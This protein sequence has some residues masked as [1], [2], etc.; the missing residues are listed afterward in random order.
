MNDNIFIA[1][2]QVSF[3]TKKLPVHAHQCMSSEEKTRARPGAL[4]QRVYN[5]HQQLS[6]I[7]KLDNDS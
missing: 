5:N 2:P 7:Y 3:M 6:P 1:T 4:L